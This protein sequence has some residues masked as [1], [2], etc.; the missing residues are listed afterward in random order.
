MK[1]RHDHFESGEN[2][3]LICVDDPK[4]LQ[5]VSDQL[6]AANFKIHTGLFHEDIVLR[7]QTY[8]YSALVVHERFEG[9]DLESNMV[10]KACR[11]LSPTQRRAHFV[12][13]IGADLPTEDGLLAFQ[14]SV[15]LVC[16]LADLE[17]LS[18]VLRRA[19]EAQDLSYQRFN[20]CLEQATLA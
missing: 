14:H 10:L 17:K 6:D 12:V 3:A 16:G 20:Q 18:V 7:L 15:D 9:G 4:I 8:T 19:L 1:P 2:A 11:E 5:I 13:L